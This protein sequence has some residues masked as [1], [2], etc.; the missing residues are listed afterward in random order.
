MA[1]LLTLVIA[2]LV[3]AAEMPETVADYWRE[4]TKR[5][6]AEPEPSPRIRRF[7]DS[8]AM[9]ERLNELILAGEKTITATSPWLYGHVGEQRPQVGRYSVFLDADG[10]P[11][12]ALRTTRVKT[13]PFNAVTAE[14][15]QFEGEAVR[16]IAQWRTVHQAYFE[17]KLEALGRV[18]DPAMPITLEW[19]EVVCN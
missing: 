8:L 6:D 3:S 4:C 5:I 17:P 19:F 16:P 18:W 7:G 2:A 11:A 12:G 10:A 9:T 14:E 15:S 1:A 13:V